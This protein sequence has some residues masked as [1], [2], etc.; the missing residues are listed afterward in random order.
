MQR[1]PHVI[2][3][4]TVT[5]ILSPQASFAQEAA[6]VR[7][8]ERYHA[9][10]RNFNGIAYSFL[11]ADSGRIYEGR[12]WGQNGAHTQS[13]RNTDGHGIAFIGDGTKRAPTRKAWESLVWLLQQGIAEGKVAKGY[14]LSGHRDWWR[15]ACPGDLIY[16]VMHAE[17]ANVGAMPARPGD[18]ITGP[19]DRG[20]VARTWQQQLV[21][22]FGEKLDVDGD[23][24]PLTEA[25][26]R[27]F[28]TAYGLAVDG[29][30]STADSAQMT[31]LYN[32]PPQPHTD[33]DA[34]ED[35]E[36]PAEP[37][38]PEVVEPRDYRVA[39][40]YS[41]NNPDERIARA[42][43]AALHLHTAPLDDPSTVGKVYLVGG[44][45]E[46]DYDRKRADEVVE[47]GGADRQATLN[48][49]VQIISEYIK[50][51]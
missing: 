47:L 12:G 35:D 30:V 42:L 25:A 6:Q 37:Q 14:R 49:V 44:E 15:K 29:Y 28:E 27:R 19:G 11:I 50:E 1:R 38:G 3:H 20:D 13:G 5:P 18:W 23:F 39:V 48:E 31:E 7:G 9:V 2:V 16:N 24:G 8:M 51:L 22:G 21:D 36:V 46:R 32:N 43:G 17:A 4:T 41:R 33:G 40:R 34:A 10:N 45:A 26:T